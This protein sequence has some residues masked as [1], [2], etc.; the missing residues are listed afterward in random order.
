MSDMQDRANTG[1]SRMFPKAAV[2]YSRGG[3]FPDGLNQRTGHPECLA[4]LVLV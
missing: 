4:S 2:Q 3:L 1:H